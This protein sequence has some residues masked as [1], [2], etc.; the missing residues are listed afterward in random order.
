MHSHPGVPSTAPFPRYQPSGDGRDMYMSNMER[1]V[2]LAATESVRQ[3]MTPRPPRTG[4]THWTAR[5]CTTPCAMRSRTDP[6]PAY[7]PSGTGRDL[8]IRRGC[9]SIPSTGKSSFGTRPPASPVRYCRIRTE[10]VPKCK[11]PTVHFVLHASRRLERWDWAR[12]LHEFRLTN[13]THG[14]GA[15]RRASANTG[16]A[17][18]SLSTHRYPAAFLAKWH[19]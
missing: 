3:V 8:H 1:C 6:M 9:Q 5:P 11:G 7:Q 19:R 2:C 17:L 10:T 14:Q 13:S 15:M 12:H 16:I 4:K 18:Q